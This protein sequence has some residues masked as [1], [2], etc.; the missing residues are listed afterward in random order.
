M[1][2]TLFRDFLDELDGGKMSD[3]Y[4][5][6]WFGN[7]RHLCDVFEDMRKCV[8]TQNFSTLKGLIEEAQTMG[9]RM[10]S[11]LQDQK[12]LVNLQAELSKARKAYKKLEREYDE[13]Y[14]AVKRGRE[15]KAKKS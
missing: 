10:E 3:R 12:D 2:R 6:E 11:A 15:R 9:N 8:K 14:P 4:K 7:N 13:L 1:S 5:F